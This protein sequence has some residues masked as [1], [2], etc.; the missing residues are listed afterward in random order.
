VRIERVG[1]GAG[2]AIAL[3]WNYINLFV[4]TFFKAGLQQLSILLETGQ[5]HRPDLLTAVVAVVGHFLI[6]M[7]CVAGC[8]R[9]HPGSR[10]GGRSSW[11]F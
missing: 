8:V 7:G 3:F 11:P 4:T 6:I 2:C 9:T 5:L 1:F 10:H